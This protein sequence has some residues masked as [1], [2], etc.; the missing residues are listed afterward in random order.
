MS[1]ISRRT[2]LRRGGQAIAGVAV[3]PVIAAAAT[4]PS[5]HTTKEATVQ[6]FEAGLRV[7]SRLSQQGA[8]SEDAER[9]FRFMSVCADCGRGDGPLY[10]DYWPEAARKEHR[11]YHKQPSERTS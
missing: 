3:L 11:R 6:F 5:V 8:W 10:F 2:A 7:R 1:Q 9:W 4:E